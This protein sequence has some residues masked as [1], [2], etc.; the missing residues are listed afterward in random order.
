MNFARLTKDEGGDVEGF[1][2]WNINTEKSFF[3]ILSS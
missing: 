3:T 2:T 1:I